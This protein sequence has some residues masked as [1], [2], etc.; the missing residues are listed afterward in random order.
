MSITGKQEAAARRSLLFAP[1][2]FR[3]VGWAFAAFFLVLCSYYLLR[4]VRDE[5]AV[6]YGVNRLQWLFSA[7]FFFTLL[8][9]PLFGWVVRSLPRHRVLPLVYGFLVINLFAFQAVFAAGV[10]PMGAA[11]F[12]VWLSVFNL[13]VVSLFWSRMADCFTTAE[14]HRLY[15]YIAAGGTCGAVAGPA[16]AAVLAPHLPSSSLLMLSAVMLAA[17]AACALCLPA[18]NAPV[19]G[20]ER[21]PVGGSIAAGIALV[22][23]LADLRGIAFL[24][25]CYTTVSTVL[26]VE[27]VRMV[28]QSYAD[29][30]ERTSFFAR[31]DLAVNLLAL[32]LQLLGTRKLVGRFG[33]RFTLPVV[34]I[35]L[36]AALALL[37]TWRN[38]LSGAATQ[39]LH[40]AGEYA[41]GKPGREM[42]YTTLDAESRYKAKNFIDTAVYR[43]GDAGSAWAIAGLRSI[44]LDAVLFAALPAALLWALN[45]FHLGSRHDRN[46]S[47]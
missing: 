20:G 40:R 16:L 23:R 8:V 45:A 25:L 13:F 12:F 33:L 34:P 46:Q 42:I 1:G 9:V 10:S 14:S 29:A 31:V 19:G 36:M 24:I 5:M 6:Q 38:L 47:A 41:L 15:G 21:R 22:A 17:A 18:H 2:E 7:T 37:G 39:V 26:Y 35:L 30:G 32:V 3:R 27:M 44:G 43:A 11:A 28:G 4:P